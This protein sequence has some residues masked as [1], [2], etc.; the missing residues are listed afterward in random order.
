MKYSGRFPIFNPASIRTYPL[1]ERQN[2][3]RWTELVQPQRALADPPAPAEIGAAVQPVARAIRRA[4]DNDWPVVL[5]SGAH[6]LKNGFGPLIIDWMRRG[7]LTLYAVNT[8]GSIHDFELALIGETSEYVPNVLARGEFGMAYEFC[9]INEA[10]REGNRRALGY[11]ESLGLMITDDAFRETV[12][13]RVRRPGAPRAFAHPEVSVLAAS[14]Y[15]GVPVTVHAI[16]GGD[17]IDQHPSFDGEAKGGA[18]GRDFLIFVE[19]VRRFKHGGV[20]IN[21]GSAVIGPEVFLKAV[22]MV[23]NVGDVLSPELVIADFD[24]RPYQP[25]AMSDER[26]FGYYFRDQKSVVTRI[27]QAFGARGYYV[28]GDQLITFPELFRQV[29]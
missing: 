24:I 7:I 25:Q 14:A 20:F 1:S 12:L 23:C 27:P 26:Q 2:K 22:S 28:Q 9:Y 19:Q 16:I 10:I 18:S 17:V 3:V 11:G 5:F 21:M 6:V 8:A 15:T 29:G 4:R 13:A